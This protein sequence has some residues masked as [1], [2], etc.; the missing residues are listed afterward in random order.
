M[1][2]RHTPRNILSR[3]AQPAPKALFD[4]AHLTAVSL[5]VIAQQV[6]NAVEN[7]DLQFTRERAVKFLGIAAR[8]RRR[9]RAVSEVPL[10]IICARPIDPEG[11]YSSSPDSELA[12]GSRSNTYMTVSVR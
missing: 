6:Q 8:G 12:S 9:D 3:Q 5:V 2:P 4:P 10:V 11:S 1:Y 7:Q